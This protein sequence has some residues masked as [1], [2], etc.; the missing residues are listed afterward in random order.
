M[1]KMAK[2]DTDL[3]SFLE[4]VSAKF[5]DS[6]MEGSPYVMEIDISKVVWGCVQKKYPEEKLFVPVVKPANKF[7]SSNMPLEE[8]LFVLEKTKLLVSEKIAK[9]SGE[10]YFPVKQKLVI[11]DS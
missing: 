3:I 2:E 11:L 6:L 10:A 9:N 5:K 4:T 7:N 8:K 1:K